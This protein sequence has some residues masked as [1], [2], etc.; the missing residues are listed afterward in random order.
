MKLARLPTPLRAVAAVAL[1]LAGCSR[2]EESPAAG[3]AP[4][5]NAANQTYYFIGVSISAP[6]WDDARIGLEERGKQL[7]VKTVFTGVPSSD[8]QK[9]AQMLDDIVAQK[10]DGIIMAPADASALKAGIDRAVEAGVAVVTVDTDSPESKRYCYAGTANYEAGLVVGKLLAEAIGGK[11][12]VGIS[13]LA[14][15]WNL[16]ERKR[17][18]FDALKKFPDIQVVQT[19]DDRADPQIGIA[20]NRA[21]MSANPELVGIAGLNAVSGPAIAQAVIEAGKK[22]QI[23]VVCFDRDEGMLNFIE[24]GTILASVA[25]KTHLMA[26]LGL[27]MLF[28][29]RNNRIK[30]LPDWRA[31]GATGV[32]MPASIDTGIMIINKGNVAQ[33]RHKK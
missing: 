33:F 4:A 27:Q 9:Q 14:G 18:V 25:Q 26:A 7:G 13:T 6:Y 12:K 11:G 10:P 32:P 22:G 28:D 21:M 1:L 3:T 24:D 8:V 20:Q 29:L 16:E 2:Q 19:V 17:G 30:H 23:K 15:Q 5:A 31:A